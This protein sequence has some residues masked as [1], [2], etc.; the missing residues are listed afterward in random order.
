MP[1]PVTD[2]ALRAAVIA[3]VRAEKQVQLDDAA[4]AAGG[5]WT[6][7]AIQAFDRAVEKVLRLGKRLLD[8]E[9]PA[10][11]RGAR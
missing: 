11:K 1:R 6:S 5:P 3:A 4:Y 2:K 8:A 7:G 10:K 9:K